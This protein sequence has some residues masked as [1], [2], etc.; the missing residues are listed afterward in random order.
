MSI[1]QIAGFFK[2]QYIKKEV[3]EEDFFGMQ[4][5]MEDFYKL[6]TSTSNKKF[7]YLFNIS[8]K[9]WVMKLIFSLYITMEVFYKLIL[10][11]WVYVSRYAQRIQINKFAIAFQY[12]EEKLILSF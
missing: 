10:S 3:N 12:L 8:R 4:I 2:M 7:G 9:M 5:K 6:I 1:N 11:F